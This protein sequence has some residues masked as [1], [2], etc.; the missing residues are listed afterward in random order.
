MW[1]PEQDC[2]LAAAEVVRGGRDPA[3]DPEVGG[4]QPR[5]QPRPLGMQ[6]TSPRLAPS[7]GP[8]PGS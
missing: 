3:Q 8:S 1:V 7:P 5:T 4:T 6:A 2:A